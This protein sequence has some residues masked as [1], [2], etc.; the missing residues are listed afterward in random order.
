MEDRMIRKFDL[1]LFADGGDGGSGDGS[2]GNS[3]GEAGKEGDKSADDKN[4]D[5]SKKTDEKTFNQADVDKIIQD[6]L[7]R[8]QKTM[9][10]QLMDDLKKQFGDGGDADE[11]SN[12]GDP[13]ANEA[14][15]KAQK[16]LEQANQ[17]MVSATA[18]TEAVKLGI[19]PKYVAG[20]VKLADLTGAMKEDGSIDEKAVATALTK[21][22]TDYPMFKTTTETG[23]GFK[24]GGQGQGTQNQNGWVSQQPKQDQASS[25]KRWNR[26]NRG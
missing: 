1:Q 6:R 12:A 9:K 25:G 8:E 10:K 15:V 22:V 23:G 21:V 7:K 13:A 24:V 17:R 14:V 3:G 2:Q 20:A 18:T 19:D 11:K 16:M 26:T 5:S 4:T